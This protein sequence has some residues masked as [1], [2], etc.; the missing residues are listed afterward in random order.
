MDFCS[1]ISTFGGEG[2][3]VPNDMI[4]ELF[5]RHWQILNQFEYMDVEAEMQKGRLTQ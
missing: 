2:V 5:P 3:Q 4:K 1:M